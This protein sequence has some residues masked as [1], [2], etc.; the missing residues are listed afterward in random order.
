MATSAR[1]TEAVTKSTV[2]VAAGVAAAAGVRKAL[3]FLLWKPAQNSSTWW[4]LVTHVHFCILLRGAWPVA[5]SND[6]FLLFH[7][8]KTFVTNFLG[9]IPSV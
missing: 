8:P 4:T 1:A 3:G 9:Q 2:V 5:S 6:Q 7:C